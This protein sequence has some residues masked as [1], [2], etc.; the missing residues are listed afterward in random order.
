MAS[1]EQ[2]DV[3]GAVLAD[4]SSG[5][6][7]IPIHADGNVVKALAPM[8][9][10]SRKAYLEGLALDF[11]RLHNVLGLTIEGLTL[12]KF[13]TEQPTDSEML[14]DSKED[15]WSR[16]HQAPRWGIKPRAI[17]LWM[18]GESEACQCC[19]CVEIVG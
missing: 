7:P 5:R 2:K 18:C 15:L 14:F 9:D 11:L 17:K 4:V 10:E 13:S 6:R 3:E 16:L 8:N 19:Y 1:N 12:I